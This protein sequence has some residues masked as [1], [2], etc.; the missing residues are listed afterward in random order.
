MCRKSATDSDECATACVLFPTSA[1]A[2][3]ARLTVWNLVHVANL[4]SHSVGATDQPAVHNNAATQ[5]S[6]DGENY[7]VSPILGCAET[8]FTPGSRVR[9]IFNQDGNV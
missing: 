7:D 1:Q 3:A 8:R 6:A 9:V 5:S 2:T 4:C